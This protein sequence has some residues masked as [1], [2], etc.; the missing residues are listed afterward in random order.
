MKN[1]LITLLLT[2]P[3]L[4]FAGA[5]GTRAGIDKDRFMEV[6]LFWFDKD[7]MKGSS[8]KFWDRMSPLFENVDGEKGVVFNIGW[9]MDI[10]LMWDGNLD[11]SIPFPPDMKIQPQFEDE[12]MFIGTTPQKKDLW[13]QRFSKAGS[14][15]VVGYGEW[16]YSDLKKFLKIFRSS[17][18]RHGIDRLRTGLFVIGWKRIYKSAPTQ[19]WERHPLWKDEFNSGHFNPTQILEKDTHRYGAYPD[20]FE[21]GLPITEFFGKQWGSL[22]KAVGFDMI[23]LRDAVLGMGLYSR[24]GP[25]GD[26]APSDTAAV[27]KWCDAGFNLCKQTKLANPDALVFGY[28]YAASPVGDLRV[29]LFDLEEI[30]AAGYLD[31]YIDQSWAGGWNE[32]GQRSPLLHQGYWNNPISG[33]TYQLQ[34]I[35][36]HL[37]QLSKTGC[38]HYYLTETF[39]SRESWNTINNARDRLK[40]GIWAYSHAA[41]KTPEGLIFPDGAYIS[42]TH[43]VYKL[44]SEE[45]VDFIKTETDAAQAD[46]ENI[47]DINGPVVVYSRNALKWQNANR[48]DEFMKEWIDEYAGSVSKWNVPIM[49][50][51][52]ME[53]IDK[54]NAD[55]Y[56]V[57]TPV[58]LED[59]ELSSLHKIIESGKPVYI[60]GSPANGI[61]ESICRMTG[62]FGKPAKKQNGEWPVGFR[63][64]L[65][66]RYDEFTEGCENSFLTYQFLTQNTVRPDSGTEV[67]YSVNDSP[68]LVRNGNITVWDA[69]EISRNAFREEHWRTDR[70]LDE[71]LGSTVPYV[72]MS[73]MLTTDLKLA[74]K[75]CSEFEDRLEPSSW[76]SWTYKDGSLGVL[77][78]QLEEGLDHSDCIHAP[79]TIYLPENFSGRNI[80]HDIWNTPNRYIA[81]GNKFK[82]T[83]RKGESKLFHIT[84]INDGN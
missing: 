12:G 61:D 20:G 63:G 67:F 71:Y 17:A 27:R 66:G 45:Q 73:R 68:A 50:I 76:N 47:E 35:L 29:N 54:I 11:S 51:A 28:S 52:R 57:Q 79:S 5:S 62:F 24:W 23:V 37:A 60:A 1:I 82:F 36:V 21:A 31:G 39:D 3:V 49:S 84:R 74:G 75:F 34:Q 30:A 56:F 58:H 69:P 13:K 40:W 22:S 18:S 46:L 32:S 38:K 53:D 7:D 16:K 80:I 14:E 59:H 44:L 41:V 26:R 15:D 10:I 81:N 43:Q 19:F 78:A 77:C 2:V 33:W 4:A 8:D 9:L 25:F 55:L 65:N 70:S 64:C 42:W 83:L 48:P 6:D 72:I